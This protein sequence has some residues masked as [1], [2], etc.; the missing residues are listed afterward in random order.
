MERSDYLKILDEYSQKVPVEQWTAETEKQLRQQFAQTYPDHDF[1]DY[2]EFNHEIQE[3]LIEKGLRKRMF[4]D[5][6]TKEE[7][8]FIMEQKEKHWQK[9]K[10]EHGIE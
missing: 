8:D 9:Y 7:D 1:H 6:R 10:K 4:F 5:A 3:L 2:L